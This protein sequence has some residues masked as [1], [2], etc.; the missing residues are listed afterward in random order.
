[1]QLVLLFFIFLNFF[2]PVLTY[3]TISCIFSFELKYISLINAILSKNIRILKN[4]SLKILNLYKSSLNFCSEKIDTKVNNKTHNQ[5]KPLCILIYGD[6]E[7]RKLVAKMWFEHMTLRVWTECSS[8]LSYFAISY[9]VIYYKGS[10]SICQD[11]NT[12]KLNFLYFFCILLFT[13]LT[14]FS[15]IFL[16]FFHFFDFYGVL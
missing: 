8:Q 13:F 10:F 4:N 2:K 7:P 5:P 12:R 16:T 3:I 1:M 9:D 15:C 14:I 6:C 11:K